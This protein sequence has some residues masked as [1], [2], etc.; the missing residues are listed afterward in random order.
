MIGLSRALFSIGAERL[1][2]SLW[3]V[4]DVVAED[5]MVEFYRGLGQGTEV[6]IGLNAVQRAMIKDGY[7]PYYW[8]PFVALGKP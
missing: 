8:A 2:A 6:A 7:V 1:V 5:T 4:E 3:H